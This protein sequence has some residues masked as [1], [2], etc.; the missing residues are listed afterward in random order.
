MDYFMFNYNVYLNYTFDLKQVAK[1][2][3]WGGN[4]TNVLVLLLRKIK[5]LQ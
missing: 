3:K 4:R 2:E 1:S 5:L